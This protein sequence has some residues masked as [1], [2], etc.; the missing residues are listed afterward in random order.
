M[1]KNP[2]G[3][4]FVENILGER[5]KY[6]GTIWTIHRLT[7]EEHQNQKR[8]ETEGYGYKLICEGDDVPPDAEEQIVS[9]NLIGCPDCRQNQFSNFTGDGQY[10]CECGYT[11]KLN[12][13]TLLSP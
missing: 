2:T 1:V 13:A 6:N 12:V 5:I 11:N 4:T 8:Y 10:E 7:P 9:N 3:D